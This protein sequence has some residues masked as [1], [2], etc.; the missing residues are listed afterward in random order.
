M[1]KDK[2][3]TLASYSAAIIVLAL[4]L[5][6]C[7]WFTIGLIIGISAH[8]IMEWLDA[9]HETEDDAVFLD[10]DDDQKS[11]TETNN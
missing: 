1:S 11:K 10:K 2:L 7:P 4:L 5:I 9:N 6:Y 8:D 3:Y